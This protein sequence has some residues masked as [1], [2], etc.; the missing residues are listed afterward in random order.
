MTGDT[1]ERLRLEHHPECF[2]SRTAGGGGLGVRFLSRDDATV[3]ATVH[4]P[5]AWEGYRGLVHGGIIAALLDGAMTNALFAGGT[6]A[7]TAEITVRYR[8][9]L[10]LGAQATVTGR[11]TRREPPLYLAAASISSDGVVHATCTG[12]FMRRTDDG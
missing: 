11:I 10:P 8:H 1:L 3:E 2:L 7:V 5:A 4:C 6:V 9:P 12:K